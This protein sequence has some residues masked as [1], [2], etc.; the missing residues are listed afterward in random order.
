MEENVRIEWNKIKQRKEKRRGDK[1]TEHKRIEH[2]TRKGKIREG[3][4]EVEAVKGLGAQG[5]EVEGKNGKDDY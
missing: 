4:D 3:N 2:K 1:I 5:V